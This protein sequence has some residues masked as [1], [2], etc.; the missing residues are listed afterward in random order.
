[1]AIYIF[2]VIS[3]SVYCAVG[4]IRNKMVSTYLL[5]LNDIV[6]SQDDWYKLSYELCEINYNEMVFKFW[7]SF[8]SFLS[9]DLKALMKNK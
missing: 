1:M 9:E 8:D 4:L 3:V 6:H 2:I 5:N 7:R